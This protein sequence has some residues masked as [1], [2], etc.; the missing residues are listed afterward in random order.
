MIYI[1]GV[2][3]GIRTIRNVAASPEMRFSSIT[4]IYNKKTSKSNHIAGLIERLP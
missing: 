3:F 2:L 4:R 1:C